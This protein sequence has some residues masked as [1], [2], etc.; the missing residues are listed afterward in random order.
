M[1]VAQP[2]PRG[3]AATDPLTQHWLHGVEGVTK[4]AAGYV[5]WHGNDRV[6][7]EHFDY[8]RHRSDHRAEEAAAVRVALTCAALQ[9]QGREVSSRAYLD[10]VPVLATVHT[11]NT[12]HLT[13]VMGCAAFYGRYT[14]AYV[15]EQFRV[16]RGAAAVLAVEEH[17]G[18][19]AVLD[20]GHHCD[21]TAVVTVKVSEVASLEATEAALRD[22]RARLLRAFPGEGPRAVAALVK[23]QRYD[24]GVYAGY[25]GMRLYTGAFDEPKWP[26][27]V[28]TLT[29]LREFAQ[30]HARPN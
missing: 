7:V 8:G 27:V 20:N 16:A 13:D 3:H 2:N 4:D 19:T 21:P 17:T 11:V 24:S 18:L 12:R 15:N 9:E 30:A 10:W 23:E 6:L 29:V 25:V 1:Q 26:T 5:Y 28:E 22:L 14:T